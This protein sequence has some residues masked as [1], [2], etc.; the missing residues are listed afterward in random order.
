[1]V[2]ALTWTPLKRYDAWQRGIGSIIAEVNR[3]AAET[4]R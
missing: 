1:V 3:K 2:T 4:R